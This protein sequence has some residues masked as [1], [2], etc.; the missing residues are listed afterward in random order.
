M[1][2]PLTNQE[3]T[4]ANKGCADGKG[5]KGGSQGFSL[6]VA[7][8]QADVGNGGCH[9]GQ[10]DEAHVLHLAN[11]KGQRALQRKDQ[12]VDGTCEESQLGQWIQ[13][14]LVCRR[15]QEAMESS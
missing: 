4:Q 2:R 11:R 8:V 1:H 12:L 3:G 13:L 6:G 10:E 5:E 15:L 9:G 14:G 7:I